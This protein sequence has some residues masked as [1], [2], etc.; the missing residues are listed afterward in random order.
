LTVRTIVVVG[1]GPSGLAAAHEAVARGHRASVLE[2]LDQV[3]GLART[4]TRGGERFDIGPHRFFTLNPEIRDL[5]REVAGE[6]LRLVHRRTRIFYRG[7][8]F[9]YPLT[10][11][12]ALLGLGPLAGLGILASYAAAALRRR[13]KPR[14]AESFE[15]WV[16]DRFGRRLFET[17][18][19]S[20]TEKVW[21][22]PCSRI[23]AS[24]AEQ[25]IKGLSLGAALRHAF[26]H[27]E[28]PKLKTL[29]DAFMYPR[30][31][32]GQL[33]ENMVRRIEAGGGNVTCGAEVGAIRRDG[34]RVTSV[35]HRRADG[36]MGEALGDFY[37]S[38][39]PL[40]E[41]LAA[42]DPPPPAEVVAA[43]RALRYRHHVSAQLVLQGPAPFADNWIY[44]HS[45][46][47]AMARVSS[48]RNFSAE[49]AAAADRHPMTA[50][51]FCFEEDAIWRATDDEVLAL[52]G[53]ELA[54]SGLAG[55]A[56]IVDGFVVRSPRAYPVIER[57][58]E[59]HIAVI[60]AWLDRFENFLPIGRSG[61]FKYNN[62]DH[63]MATGIFAARR[64]L[65][66]GDFDPWRVNIDGVYQEGGAA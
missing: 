60:R 29:A 39:A 66:L 19:K 28:R 23:D 65:G 24:W 15:D 11:V 61:M 14:A 4:V 48:Y 22:I 50:E 1:A 54:R 34:F 13:L 5:F 21:G 33:Y 35:V 32:A 53:D 12:N 17:F 62:Q 64:A 16:V 36:L 30:H 26:F 8:F 27:S 57:G 52:A 37:L 55:G 51:Y 59:A 3:G 41:L 6:D 40:S 2:K 7:R 9:D 46:D 38:S 25:R 42:F 45:P 31:G 49:M 10:P 20:Y 18:F 44:L 63:A 56:R 47:L 43:S 58:V